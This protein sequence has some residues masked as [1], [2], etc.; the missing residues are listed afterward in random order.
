MASNPNKMLNTSGVL[1][2]HAG[3]A[4]ILFDTERNDNHAFDMQDWL[5]GYS[6]LRITFYGA[7]IM[8]MLY[9]YGHATW[10]IKGVYTDRGAGN[11]TYTHNAD[12]WRNLANTTTGNQE[13]RLTLH[14]T[15][16]SGQP[17]HF[18]GSIW[19]IVGGWSFCGFIS[20]NDKFDLVSAETHGEVKRVTVEGIGWHY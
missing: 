20:L 7:K 4:D 9:Q 10:G 18:Q 19:M 2:K 13:V 12:D 14:E 16:P 17:L 5:T 3:K 1:V 8:S 11:W 6:Q 15:H